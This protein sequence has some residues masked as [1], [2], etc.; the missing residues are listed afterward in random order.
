MKRVLSAWADSVSPVRLN[1]CFLQEG[2]AVGLVMATEGV[3]SGLVL[4]TLSVC[5]S[6][7][8]KSVASV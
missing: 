5:V 1:F 3:L 8:L 7:V 6:S 4:S 2:G